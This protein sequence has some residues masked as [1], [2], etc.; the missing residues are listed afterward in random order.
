MNLLIQ[1]HPVAQ[2]FLIVAVAAVVIT[3]IIKA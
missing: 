3:F 2:C 1:L